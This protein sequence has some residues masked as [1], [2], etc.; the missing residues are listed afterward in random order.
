MS[1][2]SLLFVLFLGLLTWPAIAQ[3]QGNLSE[4]EETSAMRAGKFVLIPIIFLLTLVASYLPWFLGR[5]VQNVMLWLSFLACL[6]GGVMLGTCFAHMLPDAREN[7]EDYLKLKGKDWDYP[8][9][10]VV[11][12][13]TLLLLLAIDFLAVTDGHG[14][15]ADGEPEKHCS[16]AIPKM[17]QNGQV[18]VVV[19]GDSSE[20]SLIVSSSSSEYTAV[21][22]DEDHLTNGVDE[23]AHVHEHS[24]SHSKAVQQAWMLVIALSVHSIFDGLSLGAEKSKSG[25]VA[26]VIAQLS[27]KAMDGLAVAVPVYLARMS[28]KASIFACTFAA[29]M[30]PIGIGIGMAISDSTKG[31]SS[32]IAQAIIMALSSG[33]FLFIGLVE[34]IPAALADRRRTKTKLLLVLIGVTGMCLLALNEPDDD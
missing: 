19:A 8:L 6:A 34:L 18:Q 33:T 27:H 5:R 31:S 15:G 4:D 10:D 20:R 2:R 26:L 24:A 21:H 16:H 12:L 14:H 13:A 25:F 32:K 1:A 3:A 17:P 9:M 28:N 22:A 11:M 23:H 29:L 7:W 30:T